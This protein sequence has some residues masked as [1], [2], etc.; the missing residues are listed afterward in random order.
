MRSIGDAVKSKIDYFSVKPGSHKFQWKKYYLTYGQD[1]W[2]V[3]SLN[4]FQRI[5]RQFFGGYHETRRS[6]IEE[7]FARDFVYTLPDDSAEYKALKNLSNLFKNTIEQKKKEYEEKAVETIQNRIDRGG[8]LSTKDRY[9]VRAKEFPGIQDVIAKNRARNEANIKN[10]IKEVVNSSYPKKLSEEAE[11]GLR[12]YAQD[13]IENDPSQILQKTLEWAKET[14][15]PGCSLLKMI[16]LIK[17]DD[18]SVSTAKSLSDKVVISKELQFQLLKD[19][20]VSLEAVEEFYKDYKPNQDYKVERRDLLGIHQR[21]Y[22]IIK[23]HYKN[24][25]EIPVELYKNPLI[26][27]KVTSGPPSEKIVE[28]GKSF[29]QFDFWV[30]DK[31]LFIAE[32]LKRCIKDNDVLRF[33]TVAQRY[34][35]HAVAK[36]YQIMTS[37]FVDEVEKRDDL[38]Y[39]FVRSML[40][41][42]DP[43]PS[44]QKME[45]V[46][47]ALKL[48]LF[49]DVFPDQFYKPILNVLR[50][51]DQ[52]ANKAKFDEYVLHINLRPDYSLRSEYTEHLLKYLLEDEKDFELYKKIIQSMSNQKGQ[53]VHYK[54]GIKSLGYLSEQQLNSLNLSQKELEAYQY[55][56]INDLSKVTKDLS[57]SELN[58]LYSLTSNENKGAFIYKCLGIGVDDEAVCFLID[59][60]KARLQK[61]IDQCLKNQSYDSL[62]FIMTFY[63]DQFLLKKENYQNL[64]LKAFASSVKVKDKVRFKLVMSALKILR[65]KMSIEDFRKLFSPDDIRQD[66]VCIKNACVALFLNFDVDHQNKLI[67]DVPDFMRSY[68][69]SWVKQSSI[70]RGMYQR[71]QFEIR[72]IRDIPPDVVHY[73]MKNVMP[74]ISEVTGLD[75]V[76]FEKKFSDEAAKELFKAFWKKESSYF[77]R[78]KTVSLNDLT[79]LDS[80]PKALYFIVVKALEECKEISQSKKEEIKNCLKERAAFAF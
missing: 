20:K 58:T 30:S 18:A 63:F 11:S 38:W 59:K 6:F 44:A 36:N 62:L 54:G 16:Y 53:L 26:F 78:V 32:V 46:I 69:E 47:S 61:V 22:E 12:L 56:Q 71:K 23:D 31:P 79:V 67:H 10:K 8:Y 34:G 19:S 76:N 66:Y 48:D 33:T 9:T 43:N 27:E 68:V 51:Y 4:L 2:S 21:L 74:E 80:M 72:R 3:V 17:S 1:G 40:H 50:H 75:F 60:D 41:L 25:E 14:K 37:A 52:N 28:A 42:Q 64:N 29:P 73:L 7:E 70:V 13:L 15:D 77:E 49:E 39:P 24:D 5:L 65:G 45:N 55:T 57:Q 35:D